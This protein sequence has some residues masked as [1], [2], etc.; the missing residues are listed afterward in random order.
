M[1]YLTINQYL[2]GAGIAIQQSLG[3]QEAGG[4]YPL[5]RFGAV[6][7]YYLPKSAPEFDWTTNLDQYTDQ[8]LFFYSE[9]NPGY[10]NSHL[11]KVTSAYSNIDIH[12]VD[13]V[14]HELMIEGFDK[15]MPIVSTYLKQR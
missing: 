11:E 6:V 14:G 12:R 9:L 10:P 5:S 13:G 1:N 8:V 3:N 4:E 2:L 15:V 7:G